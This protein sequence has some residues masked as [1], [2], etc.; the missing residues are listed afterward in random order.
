MSAAY[1]TDIPT[2]TVLTISPNSTSLLAAS[3]YTLTATVTP[4]S[5]TTVPSGSV[6]FTNGLTAGTVALNAFGVATYTTTVP[7]AS[8]ALTLSAAY[9]G[10]VP[11]YYVP[12]TLFGELALRMGFHRRLV[13]RVPESLAGRLRELRRNW[14]LRGVQPSEEAT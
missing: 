13:D 5:G 11:R 12:L 14:Y 3:S 10:S 8:G 1:T 7:T 9:Q 4:S 2:A 6:V